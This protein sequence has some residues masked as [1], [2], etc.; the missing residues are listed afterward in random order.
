MDVGIIKI[1]NLIKEIGIGVLL[2]KALKN[3]LNVNLSLSNDRN[4]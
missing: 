1:S 4:N 3:S 2:T